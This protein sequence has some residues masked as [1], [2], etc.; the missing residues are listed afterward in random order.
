M[1]R[2]YAETQSRKGTG[3]LFLIHIILSNARLPPAYFNMT[4]AP[5]SRSLL[6]L[7]INAR[8]S[9]LPTWKPTANSK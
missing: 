6:D 8:G 9:R 2:K 7:Q 5:A 4:L 3:S 1:T